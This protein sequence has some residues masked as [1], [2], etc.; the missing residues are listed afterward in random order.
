[1]EVDIDPDLPY[2]GEIDPQ[3]GQYME[4]F[5]RWTLNHRA[6]PEDPPVLPP[7]AKRA[8]NEIK[9]FKPPYPPELGGGHRRVNQ[10]KLAI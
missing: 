1:L 7:P 6:P 4:G 5:L 2:R 3:L 10:P 8:N 9:G